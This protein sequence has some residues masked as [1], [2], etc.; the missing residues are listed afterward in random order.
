MYNSKLLLLLK[1]TA[2]NLVGGMMYSLEF[3]QALMTVLSDAATEPVDVIFLHARAW[4]DEG[5]LFE[6]AKTLNHEGM[7]RNILINGSNGERIGNTH[8]QQAWPGKAEYRRGLCDVFA[9][10]KENIFESTPAFHTR[11]ENLAFALFAAEKGWK[12]AITLTQPHQL[13]RA[14]LGQVRVMEASGNWIKVYG[15]YPRPCD[16]EKMVS[17][18]QGNG[19][20]TRFSNIRDE[21]ERIT[22]YQQLKPG[23]AKADIASF[24][25]L[26]E[27]LKRRQTIT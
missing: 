1:T 23:Q 21:M 12:S 3:V 13:L 16:W 9:V 27:Y 15:A 11:E 25:E 2:T 7:A 10:R 4:F 5:G 8:P 14:M 18:N 17:G 22:A 20:I 24:E 6:L 26:F 19:E